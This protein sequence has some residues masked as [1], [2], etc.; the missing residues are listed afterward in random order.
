[1]I[2]PEF[3]VEELIDA[4]MICRLWHATRHTTQPIDLK[5]FD[6]QNIDAQTRR[7]IAVIDPETYSEMFPSLSV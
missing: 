5:R 6:V 2:F 7:A 4:Q 1:M 3:D